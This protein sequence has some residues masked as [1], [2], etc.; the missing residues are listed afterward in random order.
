M[1]FDKI[2]GLFQ[3][4]I[5]FIQKLL[6]GVGVITEDNEGKAEGYESD[7]KGLIDA[8]KCALDK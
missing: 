7:I 2:M 5:D 3:T 6:K 1:D 8:I 4:F